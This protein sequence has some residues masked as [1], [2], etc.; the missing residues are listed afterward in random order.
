MLLPIIIIIRDKTLAKPVGQGLP[1]VAE[2]DPLLVVL[3]LYVA[4]F[5]EYGGRG[6]DV[7]HISYDRLPCP[8]I[9]GPAGG[10][11]ICAESG[12]HRFS[13]ALARLILGLMIEK[14]TSVL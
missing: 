9:P 8:R 3:V 4:Q 11:C 6:R 13:Q 10:G 2:D 7:I 12:F 5:D 1:I 14:K